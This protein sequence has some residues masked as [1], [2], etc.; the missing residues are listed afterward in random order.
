MALRQHPVQVSKR[1]RSKRSC[2]ADYR[3]V[4]TLRRGYTSFAFQEHHQ[5]RSKT[6]NFS[7]S[8]N[9]RARGRNRRCSLLLTSP[10]S[11]T[12]KAEPDGHMRCREAQ[13]LWYNTCRV[14]C[15]LPV[16]ICFTLLQRLQGW[17]RSSSRRGLAHRPAQ[18]IA[19][20]RP[21]PAERLQ[22]RQREK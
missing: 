13:Q 21:T 6:V 3:H 19:V 9:N 17:H 7:P 20:V 11:M 14:L 16:K 15:S 18:R 1:R 2:S 8:P 4:H 5:V 12:P 10:N 22:L